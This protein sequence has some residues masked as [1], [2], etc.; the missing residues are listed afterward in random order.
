MAQPKNT[1]DPM[2]FSFSTHPDRYQHLKIEVAH[3]EA[4]ITIVVN[5]TKGSRT[6]VEL[7][8]NSYDL[9]VDIELADAINRL[10]FGH[11]EVR[12][13]TITSGH[14]QVFSS[15]A[16]IY[17]LKKSSHAFKVNFCKYTN[18]T[19]LYIEEASRFSNI[20]FLCALNGTAAGGGY[21]LALACDRVVLVDDKS[22]NVSLPEV[23][24]LGVLPGT[25]GLTRV[26]DKRKVRRDL[27]DVF[28][29]VAE[30]VK[31]QKAK[32]WRLVDEIYA[33][34]QWSEGIKKEITALKSQTKTENANGISLACI[35]Q[36]TE[37]NGFSY[38]FVDVRIKD[39]RLARITIKAPSENEPN[40][41][42]AMLKKGSDLW[43]L[44]AF[45]ELDDAIL[46]LRFFYRDIGLWEIHTEGS[47]QKILQAER[48][49]YEAS[50]PEAHWFLR[51]LLLHIGRVFKRIDVS[52]R[53]TVA[54]ITP[55][56]SFAGVLAEL[57]FITDRS[58]AL[59]DDNQ[60]ASIQLSPMSFGLLPSWND[61]PRLA[62]RYFGEPQILRGLKPGSFSLAEAFR[63][64]LITFLLDEIDFGDELRLF[65]EERASM[66][67]DALSAMEANLRFVGPETMAT[68]IFGRLSAWQNWVF[69]RENATGVKGALISY[70]EVERPEFDFE[71]C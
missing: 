56:S 7:K 12:V 1:S 59:L 5:P 67:P 31:G 13:V 65:T 2:N 62:M 52:A 34:S 29:T 23:P 63:L 66:S 14:A 21:E 50:K 19:R 45:R 30:G 53:S 43:L 15:G 28:S 8:L 24:L 46:R 6:D 64:G 38:D 33:K 70:G 37:A 22:A 26:T 51:E 42:S 18:E 44:K 11:P 41:V 71:R 68:K 32:D 60:D 10:R 9:F 25:G 3:D 49:L 40:D 58:Y 47:V 55:S 61:I 20:K 39:G 69:I 27:A 16:N 35:S 4:L 54:V 48:P 36:N 17:M 57:L